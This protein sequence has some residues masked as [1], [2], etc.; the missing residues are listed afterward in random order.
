MRRRRAARPALATRLRASLARCVVC[1]G[2][3][4]VAI[5]LSLIA[6][7]ALALVASAS[8]AGRLDLSAHALHVAGDD[9]AAA[10]YLT[11]LV[12]L[13]FFHHTA[14][15][16][17]A[18][19]PGLVLLGLAIATA[20]MVAA[21]VT[22]GS[23]RKR[24]L[25]AT[26]TAVPYALLSGLG[27]RYV[28]LRIT[29]P[30]IG[31]GIPVQPSMIEA[32]ALP[33]GWALLFAPLGGLVGVFGRGW[34]RE[35]VRLLGAWMTPLRC[36]L[37]A[38]AAGLA[39]TSVL[40]LA[41]GAVLVG[42]SGGARSFLGGGLGHA[43]A[44][45]GAA[46]VA[47]PTLVL[48]TFLACFG[49]SFDWR[50]EALTST[51][52]SGSILGGTLPS[53]AANPAHEIPGLLAL[54]LLLATVTVFS[55]GW[56]TARRSGESVRLSMANALR[57][58]AL[59][60]LICWLFGLVSRV[61]AQAGGLLGLHVEV[62][63]ASLLWRVPLWCFLGS[64]AGSV[65]YMASRG[66]VGRRQL[67]EALLAAARP[68]RGAR[69][70]RGWLDSWRQGPASRAAMGISFLS[71]PALLIGMGSTGVATSASPAT[72]SLA[73]IHQAAEQRLRRDATPGERLA[74]TVNPST[75][76]VDT[77]SVR[78]PLHALGISPGQSPVLKAKTALARY[79]DLFGLSHRPAELGEPQE[80]TD[81][82]AKTDRIKMTHVYFKQ[83]VDGVP[84]FT[85]SI[86]VHF[87]P[88]GQYLTFVSGSIVPEVSIADN[89]VAINSTRAVSLAKAAL[90]VGELVQPPKLEVYA[91]APSRPV[92]PTA[93]LAWF[94]WLMD[95]ARGA[96][97]EYVVDAVDGA[98]LNV[99]PKTVYA[100]NREVYNANNE[101]TL[102]G[103]L[104]RKEGQGPTGNEDIDHAYEYTGDVYNYYYEILGSDSYDNHGAAIVSSAHYGKEYKNAFWNGKQMVFGDGYASAL[105]VVGHELTHGVTEHTANEVEEGQFGS[106]NEGFS[107]SMGEWIEYE[108]TKK[109]DWLMGESLPGGA[110]RSLKEPKIYSEVEG[111]ADP[112]KLSE[113][114]PT[115]L[116]NLGVHENSTII[117]HAFYLLA[118]SSI[119]VQAA[120][121][122]FFHMQTEYLHE[123][124]TFEDA[125][126][127][128]LEYAL[129]RWLK[130]ESSQYKAVES[131]FN[132][133]GLNGVAEPHAIECPPT[134]KC[135]F[136]RALQDQQAANGS[137][138]TLS[139]LA[140]LYR[141]RGELAQSSAA[142]SHFMPL[143]EENMGRIT[144]LVSRDPTLEEMAVGGLQEITPALNALMEGEGNK[145]KLSA[146]EMARIEAA[147]KRL[148]QDDRLFSG[149]GSLAELIER[150][151]K[152]LH[153]PKYAGMTYAAG[154]K[155]LNTAVVAR[156]ESPPPPATFIVD[157]NCT[158][159]P[160]SNEFEI[161]G[162]HVDTPGHYQPGE[163]SPIVSSGVVCG[164]S[165]E[166][167]GTQTECRGEGTLNTRLTLELP[168]GD[169]VNS[170]TKMTNGS[171]VGEAIGRAVACAGSESLIIY[172]GAGIKSVKSWTAAQCP[173]SAIACYEGEA[174][175]EGHPGH[176]YS[177]VTEEAGKRLVFT[178]GPVEVEVE[179][180]KVPVGFTEFGV[181]L[182][183]RAGE[184]GTK[185][186]GTGTAPWI[187]ENGE[188]SQ[189]GCPTENG[190]YVARVTNSA[191]KTTSAARS[192]VH[193]GEEAYKQ[194]IDAGNSLN[195][196][197]CVPATTEC[198]VVDN[199]GNALYSTNVSATASATWKT[200][201]GPASPGEAVAC[202]ASSLCT[203]ADGKVSEGGGG[204]MYY[205]TK[206]GGSWNEAV[207]LAHGVLAISCP[208]SS[209]CVAAQ[210]SGRIRY[211]TKP[212]STS[213][214]EVT[215]GSGAMNGVHCLSSS[216]CAV[217]NGSGDL[218]VANTEAHI[219]EASGWKSTDIDGST[220]L[221]G[222][223]CTS[224][225]SCVAVDSAGNVLD[226]TINGSGEATASKH[227]IDGTTNLTA[228][229]CTK[230]FT[231]V[232]VDN[233]GNIF[234]ST[235]SGET[236]NNQ[237]ALGTGLT[238]VSCA[239]NS[240]CVAADTSG[241]VTAF[242]PAGVPPN[243]T[244][245]I[246]A[247]NS[248]NAVSCV[249]ATTECVAL[250]NKGN[251]LYS[252]SVSVT[253]PATWKIWSG[254]ASPGEAVACPASSLC[255]L[256]DGKVSEGTGGNMYYA[257]S[258][259]GSWKEA[260]S[261]AFG[262]F[263]VSCPSSSFC[264]DGQEGG[265]IRYSTKPASTSW[266]SLGIGT[267]TMN[268]VFCLS[269]SFCAVADSSGNVWIAN[270]EAHVKEVPGWKSTDV[271]GTTALHGVAC[272]STTFCVAVDG[273]GNV[274]DLTIN[275]SGEATA[276]KQ[277]IDGT[278][279][280]TAITCTGGF[281]CVTV[282]N[283][284]NVFV[285]S[286]GGETWSNEHTLGTDLT[287]ISCSV[288]AL[289]L[290]GDT[291]G[292]VTA[293]DAG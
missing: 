207:K 53:T 208:S 206:L 40:V 30:G 160:Y 240:L 20:A 258:L 16:R 114:V 84:V 231:C 17:F 249:P 124:S 228:V 112:E 279:N 280:L 100:R 135:T 71:L 241:N 266:T 172:G 204:N 111:I 278:N 140:T 168:P 5:G 181:K 44:G 285:S 133:V 102:P 198:V 104:A 270:T 107:D 253:A 159:R 218:Y 205:A 224:T 259:G 238:S 116:D 15:L 148:A 35:A 291:T 93:R 55:A 202:P 54:L 226:L 267:G 97:N 43:A 67:A 130:V 188:A 276:S 190:L 103:K 139:M 105:D 87:S 94:V 210:E 126:A 292:D 22:R 161:H 19:L 255:T 1:A 70:Y 9:G 8:S 146:S 158:G 179:K 134:P 117:S 187:H 63:V 86:S 79:G 199:K 164:T 169:K 119:G 173:T 39:L 27:S 74:V 118:T 4:I 289:C 242:H 236:W 120:G 175:Y 28:P 109:A 21:R 29:A 192:C 95:P 209:F 88:D 166:K 108:T 268:A 227:D 6:M 203:L 23:V 47:L 48:S 272:S 131:A 32:F 153:L 24:M 89:T 80:V 14:G 214:T 147:L 75:R 290:A 36:S 252:L 234:V 262:V 235:S 92:G 137:A 96:S 136:V 110:I 46:L 68:S 83:M 194:A 128:A 31:N 230:E 212:A 76:V 115:C 200:W 163:V 132:A 66:A 182:C 174:T 217:V 221:H 64:I 211:S 247:G 25:L 41:G 222:V 264:V 274:L 171:W 196:V 7:S 101:T 197:S 282:D 125:R 193:W 45:I 237:H 284:G 245:E 277:N 42:Q 244:Q 220:A 57:A 162:F 59:M 127:A 250:D 271:D 11:Q 129:V 56:L 52:G 225:T 183:A 85:G 286:N 98:I 12:S 246:D 62:D 26:L 189:P 50:A 180:H 243:H 106:L 61:D 178:T 288:G 65:A 154:F 233:K 144:E 37:R 91:G 265:F 99:L 149:G 287:S 38:L 51:H 78:I 77:A 281:T 248:V 10:F 261:P 90:P 81:W 13:S 143:Y 2:A 69:A 184:P 122:V 138:S 177:W 229:T 123:R 145:F 72:I 165:V 195:A 269:A 176:G 191:M 156:G 113:Y 73:P 260:F 152:W 142:G 273:E 185:T 283:K 151:L 141:A 60:T 34:R 58:G 170:T 150:E 121:E 201:S 254:P 213:W 263:A 232:A 293:F 215:A 257:T 275:S 33:L 256:A 82:L 186:C 49:V 216:F 251:A 18:A 157:P 239:S 167:A 3:A 219:K 155:R 223:A